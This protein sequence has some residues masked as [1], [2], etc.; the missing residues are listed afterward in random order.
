M[1][2]KITALREE[3][4]ASETTIAVR[5]H[6]SAWEPEQARNEKK[7]RKERKEK[8]G[9]EW[10]TERVGVWL[11]KWVFSKVEVGILCLCERLIDSSLQACVVY[12]SIF[13]TRYFYNRHTTTT[14]H[15]WSR[16]PRQLLQLQIRMRPC[17]RA[18]WRWAGESKQRVTSH[19][20]SC[21]K[22]S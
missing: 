15:L 5:D 21:T 8:R 13:N 3:I 6:T 19:E 11:G 17:I 1:L 12:L 10:M 9:C 16:K 4:E 22:N 7:K 2:Q 18:W 14:L 20:I